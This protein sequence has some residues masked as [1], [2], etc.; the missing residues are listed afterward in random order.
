MT[1]NNYI[2][3]V[4]AK[5]ELAEGTTSPAE[6]A[7]E[8]LKPLLK[9]WAG[10]YLLNLTLCGSYAK[11]TRVKGGTDIDIL[12]SLGP[13]TP[14]DMAKVYE[15]FFNWLRK[16]GFTPFK[17]N[18]ALRLSYHGL[19]IHLIPAK[20]EWGTTNDHLIFETTRNRITRTNFDAHI[21]LIRAAGRASEIKA[22]KIWRS[23]RGLRF[24][25][26]CLELVVIHALRQQPHDVLAGNMERVLKCL[27]DEFPTTPFRDPANYENIVSD[28][29]LEHE[30]LA[31]A[32]A[33]AESL[34]QT[35]WSKIIW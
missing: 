14:L 22:L 12:I 33:A 16:R 10:R 26:F 18:I 4:L 1:P 17:E 9:E 21:K 13:R 20:Q 28:E 3:W 7:V 34:T 29:L 15:H 8:E 11:G 32:D 27:R 31:I 6:K 2:R 24:P 19:A 23:L 30:K 35:T 25:S 5:Y